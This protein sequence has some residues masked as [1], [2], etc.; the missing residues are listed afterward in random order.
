R[1]PPRPPA[2]TLATPHEIEDNIGGGRLMHLLAL[3]AALMPLVAGA[4]APAP[5]GVA[6]LA[7]SREYQDLKQAEQ[8]VYGRL[9]ESGGGFRLFV[10]DGL[11][12]AANSID[13][14]APGKA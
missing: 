9:R 12:R 1:F 14:H 3:A 11:G 2:S 7:G 8:F 4:G 5:P 13:L 10:L 6:V